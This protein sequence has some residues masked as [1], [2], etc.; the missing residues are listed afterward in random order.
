MKQGK[1][2]VSTNSASMPWHLKIYFKNIDSM[3]NL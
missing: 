3:R 1:L 2:Y